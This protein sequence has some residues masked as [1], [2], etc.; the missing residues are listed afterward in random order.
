M[1]KWWDLPIELIRE[2]IELLSQIPNHQILDKIEKIT[3]LYGI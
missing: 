2:N 3:E 1:L